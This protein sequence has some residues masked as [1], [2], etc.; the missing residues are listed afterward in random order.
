M[1]S[2]LPYMCLCIHIEHL[3]APFLPKIQ[4][5]LIGLGIVNEYR[6]L[7]A[8]ANSSCV[9]IYHQCAVFCICSVFFL[10]I[11]YGAATSTSWTEINSF[12]LLLTD[13]LFFLSILIDN[14]TRGYNK[15]QWTTRALKNCQIKIVKNDYDD[16]ACPR[17]NRM[18]D[19][20]E[21]LNQKKNTMLR[22]H[23]KDF[24]DSWLWIFE[25]AHFYSWNS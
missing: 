9:C 21:C 16:M 1:P 3:P 11:H 13:L 24:D 19:E 17:P 10:S 23:W 22:N 15:I 18:N 12:S 4:Q 2:I 20:L 7:I 6:R 5:H 25:R 8:I 14:F